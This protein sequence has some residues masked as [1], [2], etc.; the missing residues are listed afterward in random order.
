MIRC[1]CAL[2]H[3]LTPTRHL[4]LDPYVRGKTVMARQ[5]INRGDG[6]THWNYAGGE[7]VLGTSYNEIRKE[8]ASSS[9]SRTKLSAQ[10]ASRASARR[11][12][13]TR[14]P[15]RRRRSGP[16]GSTRTSGTRSSPASRAT[17]RCPSSS[18]GRPTRRA[19]SRP[20]RPRPRRR[21]TRLRPRR[22]ATRRRC[23]ASVLD[24]L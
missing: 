4:D 9:A 20:A 5:G 8:R 23:V 19:R 21:A 6:T 12:A 24:R 10:S 2:R 22:T 11:T 18:G 13:P 3:V 16:T 17:R 15:A 1:V 7:E 14:R